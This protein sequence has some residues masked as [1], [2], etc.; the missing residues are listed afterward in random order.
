MKAAWEHYNRFAHSRSNNR[1]VPFER[2]YFGFLLCIAWRDARLAATDITARRRARIEAEI[3]A[4]SFKTLQIN[5]EPMRRRLDAEL[6]SLA[7]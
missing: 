6:S 2:S 1:P 4:L 3:D 7:T 5:T